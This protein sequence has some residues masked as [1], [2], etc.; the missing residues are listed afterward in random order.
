MSEDCELITVIDVIPGRLEVT[1]QH[2][3]FFDGSIEKEEGKHDQ[4]LSIFSAVQHSAFSRL[5]LCFENKCQNN[6]KETSCCSVL[7]INIPLD[8]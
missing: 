3:Y 5:S 6:C 7:K 2:I 4:Y 8:G 1:T